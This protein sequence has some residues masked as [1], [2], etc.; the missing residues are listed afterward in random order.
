[1]EVRDTGPGIAPEKLGRI[2]D[3]FFTTK[4]QGTGLGLAIAKRF[5]EAHGGTITVDSRPG[6]GATFR[7]TLPAA[8]G[9]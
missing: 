6:E 4:P 2:F 1:V 7:V 3:I 5:T 9:A 8:S